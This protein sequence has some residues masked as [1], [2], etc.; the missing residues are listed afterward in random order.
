MKKEIFD[1]DE[2]FSN[3]KNA[4][5]HRDLTWIISNSNNKKV[6]REIP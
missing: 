2:N 3:R 6:L 5:F 4:D 1:A